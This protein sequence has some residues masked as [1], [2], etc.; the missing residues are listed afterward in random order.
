MTSYANFHPPIFSEIV[1]GW[2][3]VELFH[4]PQPDERAY[5]LARRQLYRLIASNPDL[6]VFRLNNRRYAARASTVREWFAQRERAGRSERLKSTA[7]S[8]NGK[9][10]VSAVIKGH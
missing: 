3:L 1:T 7:S 9:E 5:R 8:R 6:P 10:Q 2:D 4:G